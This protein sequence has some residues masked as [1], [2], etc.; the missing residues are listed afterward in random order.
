MDLHSSLGTC[1]KESLQ[2]LRPPYFVNGA[3]EL[4]YCS[5]FWFT[6][7]RFHVC[8][9]GFCLGSCCGSGGLKRLKVPH[10]VSQIGG[11]IFGVP[12]MG[13]RAFQGLY[14]GP[15]FRDT[16]TY[17]YLMTACGSPFGPASWGSRCRRIKPVGAGKHRLFITMGETVFVGAYLGLL[18][19]SP[20]CWSGIILYRTRALSNTVL[21]HNHPDSSTV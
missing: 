7:H 5:C 13:I 19:K 1:G 15:L 11:T 20:R 2:C 10:G 12:I 16:T 14:L 4:T 8:F 21:P 6:M 17:S 9:H 3:V 18:L